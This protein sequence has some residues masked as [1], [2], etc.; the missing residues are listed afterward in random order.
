[1]HTST[2]DRIATYLRA[3]YGEQQG[4][5]AT[6]QL[7]AML[8]AFVRP[9]PPAPLAH[10]AR[11][12]GVRA[13]LSSDDVILIT[14]GD[15]V[16]EPGRPPL[17]TLGALLDTR[18]R[19][20][21]SGVHILPFSPST[22]DDGFAV[23]D[24]LAVDPALGSWDDIARIGACH[25]LMVDAVVNHCSASSR[26]FQDFLAGEPGAE[27]RFHSIDPATD[28]RGV[29]RPRTTPLLTPFTTPDG[30]RHIWTT[31]SADQID[32][33][34]AN[35]E[36]LLSMTSVLLEYVAHGASMIR[37]DA[38]GYLWKEIGT[39]CIHLPQAH[40]VVQ[41]WRA[42]L[43]AV[44]PEVLL[45]SET[46]V[47]HADN[48][49]YFGNGTNE[50][51]MVYQFPLAPLVLHAFATG[52]ATTLSGWACDL[53][54][55]A[56]TCA[57]FNFLA[58]HDG[59]GVVPATGILRH[60]EVRALCAQVER[61]GGRVSYK[62]NPSGDASPYELNCTWFDALS[63]PQGGEPQQLCIDRFIASQ[64]IML[65]LQGVPGIYVHSL[66]GSSNDQAGFAETGRARTL[67]RGRWERAELE[68]LLADE[69]SRA[70][71]IFRRMATLLA[72]RRGESAF[73]PAGPQR[74]RDL[75]AGL[76]AIERHTPGGGPALLCLH[77]VTTVPQQTRLAVATGASYRDLL[78]GESLVAGVDGAL[79][80][81][82]GP[83]Q[84]RWLKEWE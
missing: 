76:F 54:P 80:V 62:N 74:L 79:A 53:A 18:L 38:I 78:S 60:D 46:N 35:P 57:F 59:I 63:D 84:V 20:V 33:N 22:S 14:Y 82:L 64:A 34:F 27:V 21:V 73:H 29:T 40:Q 36:V 39:R 70:G 28:L 44:A 8:A 30:T 75:G 42:V 10:G 56:P 50:A 32:L 51:Q 58:S 4:A 7:A 49:S 26:W 1:M 45:I 48:I 69:A 72:I 66:V 77:S 37:L 25:R 12:G 9:S 68:V 65:A 24:Y 61:H 83:Y 47:P 15:Q 17:Q 71:A 41:F 81:D 16:R 2:S 6:E 11:D 31:F 43:D 13:E 5:A 52:D 23:V 67:N 19:G 55:P 3:L